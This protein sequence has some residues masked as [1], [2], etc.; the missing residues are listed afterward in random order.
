MFADLQADQAFFDE[1]AKDLEEVAMDE[2]RKISLDAKKLKMK[3][4]AS[5]KAVQQELARRQCSR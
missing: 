1:L 4:D 3:L 2:V 5:V